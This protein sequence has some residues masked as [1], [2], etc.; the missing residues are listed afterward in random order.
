MDKLE[1]VPKVFDKK[2]VMKNVRESRLDYMF[3]R[4]LI[5]E[6]EFIAGS[7]YRRLC[8]VSQLGGRASTYMPRIDFGS[9]TVMDS[10]I[11]AF[12]L[13]AEI[14]K[15]LES[16]FIIVLKYFCYQNFG[17]TEMSKLL[18]L[19]QRKTSNLLHEALRSLAIYFGYVKVRNTI[20]GQGAKKMEIK[21]VSTMDS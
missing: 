20:K 18:H 16:Q 3:H 2:T 19:S 9:N 5:S 7:R 14:S 12:S 1:L 21:K 6:S 8:E 17:I 4:Q 10:K 15:E 11:G 13:L